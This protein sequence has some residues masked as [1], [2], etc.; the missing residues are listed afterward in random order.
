MPTE[1]ISVLPFNE[2]V[3]SKAAM[4]YHQLR[5]INQMIEFRDLFIAA[6]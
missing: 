2:D 4:I 1:G 6:T 5:Q 3:A